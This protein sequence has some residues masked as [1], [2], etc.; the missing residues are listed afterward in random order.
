MGDDASGSAVADRDGWPNRPLRPPTGERTVGDVIRA[1]A[2]LGV[3]IVGLPLAAR[4]YPTTVGEWLGWIGVALV[5]GLLG[6]RPRRVWIVWVGL[7]VLAAI[8]HPMGWDGDLRYFWWLSA[9]LAAVAAT[10]AYL[11][12][13][14]LAGPSSP[15]DELRRWWS[16]IGRFGHRLTLGL[17]AVIALGLVGYGGYAFIV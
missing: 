2:A 7:A 14:L 3:A 6:R 12:G 13:T 1:L 5:V 16:S 8:A 15:E 10:L 4:P 9:A 11:A 17:I